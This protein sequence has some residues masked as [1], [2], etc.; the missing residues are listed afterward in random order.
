MSTSETGLYNKIMTSTVSTYYTNKILSIIDEYS[1]RNDFTI[2]VFLGV[3][4]CIDTRAI[5]GN[6][7]DQKTFYLDG[8]EQ[9]FDKAWRRDAVKQ[10][11]NSDKPFVILSY[12]QFCYLEQNLGKDFLENVVIIQDNLRSLYQI[13]PHLY[14]RPNI[15]EKEADLEER[16]DK[17]P[18]YQAEQFVFDNK[19]FY[20]V[21]IP[22][23]PNYIIVPLFTERKQINVDLK[24]PSNRV[25]LIDLKGDSY[26]LDIILNE[27]VRGDFLY[28]QI[29]IKTYK[30]NPLTGLYRQRI[31]CINAFL[32]RLGHSISEYQ[33]TLD[34]EECHI[35]KETIS[36]LHE[37]W[38]NDASFRDIEVYSNPDEGKTL[39]KISQGQIVQTIIKEYKNSRSGTEVRDLLLTA[40]TGAGKSLIFQL[41]AFHIAKKGDVTIIVSPLIALMKDQVDAIKARGFARVEYINSLLNYIDRDRIIKECQA[42]HV[43]I[44][45]MSPELLLSYHISH[46]IGD[47]SIG[48]MV[49]DEAHLITTWGRDFRVDYWYMGEHLRKIRKNLPYSF[50]II[51]VTATAIYGG[52]NDMVFDTIDSL[53]MQ[54]PHLFI[55]KIRRED[56]LFAINNYDSPKSQYYSFKLAQ[57]AAFISKMVELGAKTIVYTPYKRHIGDI[58]SK[59][60]TPEEKEKI[61]I[62]KSD[63]DSYIK[64]ESMNLYKSGEKTIMLCTKAFGMGVDI[65]DIQVVYHHAP[66]GL[67]PD[68]IQEIGRVARDPKV[69]GIAAIEYSEK[70]QIYSKALHGLSSIKPFQIQYILKKLYSL[71]L[72]NEKKRNMV[73]STDDFQYIFPKSNAEEVSQKVQTGLM[74]IE[75]DYLAKY[76]F[77]VVIA[78]PKQLFVKAYARTNEFGYNFLMMNYKN[79]IDSVVKEENGHYWM[80]LDLDKVWKKNFVDITFPLL[81]KR[82]YDQELFSDKNLLLVPEVR[83]DFEFTSDFTKSYA[84]IS[85]ILEATSGYFSISLTSFKE[86]DLENQLVKSIPDGRKREQYVRF[87]LT[88][89]SDIGNKETDSFLQARRNGHGQFFFVKNNNYEKKFS[90]LKRLFYELFGNGQQKV[91]RYRQ[92]GGTRALDLYRLGGLFDLFDLGTFGCRG[93]ENPMIFVRIN[94]PEK[95]RRDS[96][97][98]K[99]ENLILK[100]TLNKNKISSELFDYFFMNDFDDKKRWSFIEDF[101]LG[102]DNDDLFTRYPATSLCHTNII[103]YIEDHIQSTETLSVAPKKT[104]SEGQSVSFAP[105]AGTFYS[106]DRQLTINGVTKTISRWI[107]DSPVELNKTITNYS[108]KIGKN[109]RSVLISKLMNNHKEYY[110]EFIGLNAL[111]DFPGYE[112][113]VKA[114]IPFQYEPLQFYRWWQKNEDVVYLSKSNQ[115]KLFLTVVDQGETLLKRHSQVLLMSKKRL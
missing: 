75:K 76:R 23:D 12:Q 22:S 82:F 57:T 11:I 37:Y 38:G 15:H 59:I 55:G 50:P 17:L 77:N 96:E 9:I 61:A 103:Q 68:Y 1:S 5:I 114:S 34:K 3:T 36:L 89:Y 21:D 78:R 8:G 45:Y 94:D 46:F 65:P 24:H 80:L 83:F 56:I 39:V 71:Y 6:I 110:R 107:I 62:Y 93:G 70:D 97:N 25:K 67:L 64:E 99:Y 95:V 26:A 35:S 52:D 28:E 60:C 102:M 4:E 31:E 113:P 66:S 54:R 7:L 41:P 63:L 87:I 29:V 44:L 74:M 18:V 115:I 109:S 108:I 79:C 10:I 49:I 47:R 19:Y 73:V 42:G 81:K 43:D 88:T 32:N 33:E 86:V 69:I 2:F 101:F 13:S 91:T 104:T 53:H 98:M 20:S 90:N 58:L 40:P 100:R 27:C 85:D 92:Y 48:L 30:K 16:P 112:G 105:I 106:D 84:Y 51:A 111:I 72:K 14:I